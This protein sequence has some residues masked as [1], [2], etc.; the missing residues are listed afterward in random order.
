MR[1]PFLLSAGLAAEL[2]DY[3]VP[4]GWVPMTDLPQTANGKLDRKAL[5]DPVDAPP[6]RCRT[7]PIPKP[8]TVRI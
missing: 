7:T 2:P 6:V 8:L 1:Q 5:P 4:T 3:M